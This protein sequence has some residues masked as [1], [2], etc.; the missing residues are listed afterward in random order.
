MPRR[1][2]PGAT[3]VLTRH[4]ASGQ[5]PRNVIT[6]FTRT[7][8]YIG[9]IGLPWYPAESVTRSVAMTSRPEHDVGAVAR[10]EGRIS[11][12]SGGGLLCHRGWRL[13]RLMPRW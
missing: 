11:P 7:R 4:R 8:V 1:W 12:C 3:W 13:F 9:W 10:V 6:R 2:P 5:S